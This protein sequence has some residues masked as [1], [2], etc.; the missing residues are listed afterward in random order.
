MEQLS[1]DTLK[2]MNFKGFYQ[3]K[4]TEKVMQFGQG[5]FLRAFADVFF[6]IANEKT[7]WNGKIVVVKPRQGHSYV[8]DELN[9]QDGLYTVLMRGRENGE[10]VEQTRLVSSIS[11]CIYP[12]EQFDELMK[13]AVSPDLQFIISNTTEA[14]I[15]FDEHCNLYDKPATSYPG[16]LTQV[17]YA[18]FAAYQ[19]GVVIL[20]C[21]L[22]DHNGDMLLKAID[23]Y[24]ELWELPEEFYDYVH[25]ECRVCNTLV[26]RIVSGAIRDDNELN[27]IWNENGYVDKVM[28]ASEIFHVWDIEGDSELEKLLPFK[29]AGLNCPVVPDVNPYKLRKVRILNGAHTGFVPGA[30]LAGKHIVREC[31]EDGVI[32][33]FMNRMLN[34]EVLPILPL[35]REDCAAFAASVQDRFNNPFIDHQLSAIALNT[36]AKW[37]ERN[38]PS[39]RDYVAKIG[40]LPVCLTL[41]FANYLALYISGNEALN[42]DK[43]VMDFFA[44][45]KGDAPETLV[46]AVLH[47]SFFA[48]EQLFEIPGFNEKTVENLRFIKENGAYAAFARA[49]AEEE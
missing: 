46:N 4:G 21:E 44:E 2:K 43:A 1:Y 25:K 3:E 36:T 37:K 12:D 48:A 28:V 5:N 34:E 39:L 9:R 38:L 23:D 30:I 49:L 16:K 19:P 20:P 27:R 13:L 8:C 41:S 17:L 45:H 6:D 29:Q 11:R 33:G 10:K 31:M 32:R 18:R 47:S 7:G 42:D 14:G 35:D 22:N 40:K 15:A 26:D 24:M